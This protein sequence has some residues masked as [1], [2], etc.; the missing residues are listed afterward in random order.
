MAY[1][2]VLINAIDV[3]DPDYMEV[4]VTQDGVNLNNYDF[5]LYD[6]GSQSFRWNLADDNPGTLNEGAVFGEDESNASF[7]C[8]LVDY[9]AITV[10]I[11]DSNGNVIDA[12]ST[13]GGGGVTPTGPDVTASAGSQMC[14][15]RGVDDDTNTASDWV[16]EGSSHGSKGTLNPGQTGT[17]VS[18]PSAPSNVTATVNANDSIT[19]SWD[20]PSDW[21]GEAG[22]YR[23][24]QNR[25]GNGWVGTAHS[26][27]TSTPGSGTTS[28]TLTPKSGAGYN[29]VVGIDSEFRFRVRAENSA[30]NSGFAHSGYYYTDPVGP[31]D[32]SVNRP[33][34]NE[35]TVTAT[36][37]SDQITG[38]NLQYNRDDGSGYSGWASFDWVASS[39]ETDGGTNPTVKGNTWSKTYKVGETY[40]WNY[41]AK[42]IHEN[43]R[44]QFRLK[45]LKT[46]PERSVWAGASS[47][48]VHCDYGND[49]NVFFQDGFES[50]DLSAWDSNNGGSVGT[51]ANSSTGVNGPASGSYMFTGTGINDTD[52]TYIQKNLGDLSSETNVLVNCVFASGSFDSA[53]ENFTIHWYDGTTWQV[54]RTFGWEYN[55]QGWVQVSVVMP[56]SYLSA[57]NRLRVGW[58]TGTG[59]FGGDHFAVDSVVVSDVLHEYTAPTPVSDFHVETTASGEVTGTWTDNSAFETRFE[60]DYKAPTST[61]HDERINTAPDTTSATHT[62]LTDGNA[63]EFRVQ[64]V[65][66]QD[67]HGSINR[68]WFISSKLVAETVEPRTADAQWT[69]ETDWDTGV[70]TTGFISDSIGDHVNDAVLEQG[71]QHGSLTRG[72]IGYYPMDGGQSNHVH[73]AATMNVGTITGASWDANSRYGESCLSFDGVDDYVVID[74]STDLDGFDAITVTCW[75]NF[76]SGV[77]GEVLVAKEDDGGGTD[78]WGLR[79]DG[80]GNMRGYIRTNDTAWNEVRLEVDVGPGSWHHWALT[81]SKQSGIIHL[82]RDGV[83][84]G[85]NTT[86]NLALAETTAPVKFGVRDASTVNQ[87]F[88][89][90][91]DDVRIYT[92]KL[93]SPEIQVMAQSPQSSGTVVTTDPRDGLVSEWK[94]D[95]DATDSVGSNDGTVNGT[96]FTTG[97]RGQAASFDG[98]DDYIDVGMGEFSSTGFTASM[99]FST[100]DVTKFQQ[101]TSAN[102]INGW[103]PLSH[104]SIRNSAVSWY[105]SNGWRTGATTLSNARWYH[106]ALVGDAGA[107]TVTTYL[108]GG[109]DHFENGTIQTMVGNL[110]EIGRRDRTNN[111]RYFDGKLDEFRLYDRPLSATEIEQLYHLGHRRIARSEVLR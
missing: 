3:G 58:T 89:G 12:V 75:A 24:Y 56:D 59:M 31:I 55:R 22:N 32:V 2:P 1:P 61:G 34:A 41:G 80:S 69:T 23:V 6:N 40:H 66:E 109:V 8:G 29:Y 73:D 67:R 84:L 99:W 105:G 82:Y 30:G 15:Y 37:N 74:D 10:H 21:G 102:N 39:G 68:W 48:Y 16:D 47:D 90:R 63:Y 51:T 88:N 97:I 5:V 98:T 49:G 36:C 95:G 53:S 4:I 38:Y 86:A 17:F 107:G 27:G 108:D 18:A 44:Y 52:T 33:S 94:F 87:L 45:A 60:F 81:W 111:D 35:I 77:S 101:L 50:G 43:E 110:D 104:V 25:D 100:D 54:L 7:T 93:S 46:T 65:I 19:L 64:P 83:L 13:N 85:T 71:Y 103:P 79:T 42:S 91:L 14:I 78:C 62:G 57:D 28:L 9:P 26:G 76:S 11:E 92:R 106:M 70:T 72:L 96:T 20:P